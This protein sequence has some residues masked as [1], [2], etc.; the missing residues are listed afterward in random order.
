MMKTKNTQN[1]IHAII[2]V[3]IV[4][5][6]GCDDFLEPEPQT[7]ETKE[8][9]FNSEDQFLQAVN[10]GYARLQDWVL[11]AHVLEESRSDNTTYDNQLNLG[12]SQHLA[13][14]DWFIPNTDIPQVNN[15][16]DLIFRG[17]KEANVPLSVVD[18]GIA[19]GNIDSDLGKRIEGEL[20]FIRAFFY[21]TAVRF[22]GDVPLILEPITNG[23]EAFE[24]VRDPKAEVISV[25]KTDLQSAI[26]T[27]P[28][29]YGRENYG[30]ANKNAAR[31][32]LAKVFLWN[33]EFSKAEEQLRD[34]VNSGKF[35]LL[36]NYAEIFNPDNKFNSESI[37][38]VGFKEG[39]EGES[40]NFI[41]QFAPVGSFPEVIP[42]LVNDGTWGKNLPTRDL[43]SR[44]E[45]G[46]V[47]FQASIG[48]FSRSDTDSI[49]YI[50]KWD[51]ATDPNF[52]RTNHNWPLYRYADVLLL[53]GEAINE[54]G[55][56]SGEPFELLNKIRE[57]AGL[58]FKTPSELPDQNAFRIALLHER[59]IELAFENQRWF[60]LLRSG[61]AIDVMRN[62]GDI[63]VA[64]PTT[65]LTSVLPL[66]PSAYEV[67]PY[68]LLYPIPQ[69]ELIVNP[70][71]SQNPGY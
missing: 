67:E 36:S 28:E 31:T 23:I 60:D 16:W 26:S 37:F 3:V 49:P 6:W 40:S 39:S 5:V 65:S 44:Y 68:M 38:E 51:E 66:D 4:T 33:D 69:N 24:I 35:S 42:T 10:A 62:H 18:K 27:L 21:F 1:I 45:K 46:D 56:D 59:R 12:V 8:N 20:K 34:I 52:P 43:V 61:I 54:Q 9:F 17:I 41:F 47:R 53:L 32:L 13:R 7:F 70:N 63:E 25:I 15:A 11:Q 64:N 55:Y 2:L 29:V 58:N 48:F 14:V 22:W 19:N 57:R 50:K 71:M 30:R